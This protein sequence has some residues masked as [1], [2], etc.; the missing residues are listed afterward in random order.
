VWDESKIKDERKKIKVWDE[1]KI[2]DKS[3]KIKGEFTV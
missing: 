3:I 1:S 2:K